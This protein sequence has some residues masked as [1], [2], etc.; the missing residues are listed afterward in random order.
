LGS[1][2]GVR[3]APDRL[4]PDRG[5]GLSQP[6]KRRPFFHRSGRE[7]T[8][9]PGTDSKDRDVCGALLISRSAF[10]MRATSRRSRR[11]RPMLVN[12]PSLSSSFSADRPLQSAPPRRRS[13]SR[14]DSPGS[15]P[16][17]SGSHGSGS[18]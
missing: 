1:R 16:A 12:Y 9:H 10:S 15:V 8:E 11:T 5:Q 14:N 18:F 6:S 4:H 3:I 7:W 17:L 2:R 13:S